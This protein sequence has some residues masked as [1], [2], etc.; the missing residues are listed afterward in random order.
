LLGEVFGRR[1][2]LEDGLFWRIR[3]E[4]STKIWG[5]KWVDIP[6]SYSIQ[7]YPRLLD[8]DAKVWELSNGDFF[9]FFEN[10]NGDLKSWN[11]PFL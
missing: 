2:L 11:K 3:N 9:F 6:S 4:D 8:P 5:D 7:S 10:S 1:N